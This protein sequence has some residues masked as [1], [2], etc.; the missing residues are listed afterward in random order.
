M[1]HLSCDRSHGKP[2]LFA[3]QSESGLC[4]GFTLECTTAHG[5]QRYA[6]FLCSYGEFPKRDGR[7]I[8]IFYIPTADHSECRGL[9]PSQ[10]VTAVASDGQGTA[11]IDAYKPVG[12]ASC[13][14]RMIEII[15]RTSCLEMSKPLTDGFVRE[16]GYPKSVK[17]LMAVQMVIDLAE[18][19]FT[20]TPGIG[21]Y[22]DAV[23]S[24]EALTDSFELFECCGV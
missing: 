12:F 11:G 17:G 14:G 13:L 8:T 3:K 15:I 6:L 2:A 16:R 4:I 10:R 20:F 7:K 18:D 19:E 24:V 5:F 21:G 23:G 9:Y 22:D 1:S